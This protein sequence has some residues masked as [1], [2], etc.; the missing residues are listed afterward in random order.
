M[1]DMTRWKERTA[2]VTGAS[3]GIGRAIALELAARGLNVVVCARREERLRE[4]VKEI[5]ADGGTALAVRADLCKDDDIM[6][7]FEVIRDQF[8][9]VDVLIN[10]AGFGKSESLLTGDHHRWRSMLG[11]NVLALAICTRE[12]IKDMRRRDVDG[13]VIHIS[14]MSAHRVS[15]GGGMYSATK[16]AVR[17][18][19]ESLRRELR[20]IDSDIRITSISPGYVET[21]FAK[22]FHESTEKARQNYGQYKVLQ[23][24]D[25]ADTI[26]H[27]LGAPQH[28]QYHDI[29]MRPTRQDN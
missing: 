8:G 22:V 1:S 10:N 24:E 11:V 20:G 4:L 13:H 15:E 7:L 6:A 5:E 21:E 26:R 23:P 17:S 27:V 18:L 2:L 28:V 16:F 12:A 29:L 19:T 25:I 3:S 9:G 14:S